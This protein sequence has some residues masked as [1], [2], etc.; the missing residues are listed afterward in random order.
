MK[1][2]LERAPHGKYAGGVLEYKYVVPCRDTFL[3][4]Q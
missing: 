1:A 3:V 2:P 4:L